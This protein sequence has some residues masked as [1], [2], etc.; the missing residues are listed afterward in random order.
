[1]AIRPSDHKPDMSRK[2][3]FIAPS[4]YPLG[5]VAVWLDYLVRGLPQYGWQAVAGLAAGSFHDTVAYQRAYPG[6]PVEAIRNPTGSHEGRIRALVTII[7]RVQPEIVVSVNIRDVYTAVR[8]LRSAGSPVRAVM[9]LHAIEAPLLYGLAAERATID[10]VVATNRLACRLCCVQARIQQ[11]R[12]LYAPY[13]VD[14]T[15]LGATLRSP[16]VDLLRIV[17]V[18]RFDKFQKRESDI[19]D[20]L[21]HLDALGVAYR[22]TVVGDGPDRSQTLLSLAPWIENKRAEYAGSL[23]ATE[24]ARKIY[25]KA[26][27][28]LV[29]SSWETGPIVIWEAMASGV[30]VV[31]SR[32]VGSGLEH[33]LEHETNC[34][35]FPVGDTYEAAEQLKVFA[36]NEAMRRALVAKGRELVTSRYSVEQSVKGWAASFDS[37]MNLPMMPVLPAAAPSMPSGRLDRILG[38]AAG[39]TLR[40]MSRI[41]YRHTSAG[42]EWPHTSFEGPT[43]EA[44]TLRRAAELDQ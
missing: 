16:R 41:R 18:G 29:T 6:L 14:V 13:G 40:S 28:L 15:G 17:W 36:S 11:E 25:S 2:V 10:A 8:R 21:A 7:R 39:E 38:V 31:T 5:G 23:S 27:V 30:A 24:L 22:L 43:D 9:A 44:E 33:A 26:D 3:L 20:V 42:G 35:M 37:V 32:Y 4:A 12:V 1:M 19:H 34:L